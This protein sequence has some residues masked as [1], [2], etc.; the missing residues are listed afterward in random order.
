MNFLI[1]Q[2]QSL[3][4]CPNPLRFD[5]NMT[6]LIVLVDHPLLMRLHTWRD[7]ARMSI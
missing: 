3:V 7:L 1:S 2:F 6:I 4:E 5:F